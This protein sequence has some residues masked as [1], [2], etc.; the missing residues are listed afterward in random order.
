MKIKVY[1]VILNLNSKKFKNNPPKILIYVR[2][3][4]G[5]YSI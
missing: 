1:F 5:K 2:K 4:N 3:I